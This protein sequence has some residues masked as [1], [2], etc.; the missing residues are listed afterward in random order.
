M[1]Y[2]FPFTATVEIQVGAIRCIGL[3]LSYEFDW[4][5]KYRNRVNA[6]N[7]QVNAARA[8]QQQAALTL[9]SSVASVYYQLQSNFALQNV[10]Q[11]E[12]DNND[13]LAELRTKQYQAGIYGVEIPQQTKAQAGD[14]G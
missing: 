2:L 4:W 7:A 12:V 1:R 8:E 3:N 14:I 6:A 9:T 10:L 13:R 11:Q 5:G